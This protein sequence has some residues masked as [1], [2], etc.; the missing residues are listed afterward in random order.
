MKNKLSFKA[1]AYTLQSLN[2]E[3]PLDSMQVMREVNSK[4]YK[5]NRQDPENYDWHEYSNYLQELEQKGLSAA[6]GMSPEGLT[7]YKIA[8]I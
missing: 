1:K 6:C 8:S 5:E 3:T 2:K 7:R 4:L